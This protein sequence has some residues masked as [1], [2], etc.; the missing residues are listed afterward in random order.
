MSWDRKDL[1]EL[2][3]SED[4]KKQRAK[5]KEKWEKDGYPRAGGRR[6]RLTEMDKRKRKMV[7][8]QKANSIA[9]LAAVL[10]EQDGLG[11]R[12]EG[13]GR[14]TEKEQ[15]QQERT[16]K[17]MQRL[18]EADTD[19]TLAELDQKIAAAEEQRNGIPSSQDEETKLARRRLDNSIQQLQLKRAKVVAVASLIEQAETEAIA[20][21][22]KSQKNNVS[23]TDDTAEE[24][25]DIE[26]DLPQI[27]KDKL[28]LLSV[29]HSK[30]DKKPEVSPKLSLPKRGKARK[31]IL[32]Q[33]YPTPQYTSEGV[34]VRWSNPLDAEYAETW[35]RNVQHDILGLLRNTSL[36]PGNEAI[37]KVEDIP[38]LPL[39]TGKWKQL[40][41]EEV[42]E[43]EAVAASEQEG[44]QEFV[45]DEASKGPGGGQ[46][47]RQTA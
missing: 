22:E 37:D 35:P 28:P 2:E 33:M 15:E 11:A 41:P 19:E 42:V 20:R 1:P 4:E 8:D 36:K 25:I 45:A 10:I 39:S 40:N 16:L 5:L 29:F 34:M 12:L 31:Q 27:F 17:E 14:K 30:K 18:A 38:Y 32:Q 21:H 44:S 46:E 6:P 43:M 3:F 13:Q 26:I 7:M 9:D 24:A 23:K 47:V